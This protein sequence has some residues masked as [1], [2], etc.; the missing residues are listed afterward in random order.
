VPAGQTVQVPVTLQP[1]QEGNGQLSG[2]LT[3]SL[4][5]A[6]DPTRTT[7]APIRYQADMVR[8]PQAPVKIAILIAAFL[9]CLLIPLFLIWLARRLGARF[10]SGDRVALQAVVIEVKIGTNL[11]SAGGGTLEVPPL[12]SPV[13][14]P[15]PGRRTLSLSGV[16][17]SAHAGW[18]FTEPGYAVVDDGGDSVGACS[19]PPHS[20]SHGRPRLPLSVQGTWTVLIPRGPAISPLTELSG[21][22][23]LVV[24]TAADIE[25]RRRLIADA[26]RD[27]PAAV[28]AARVKAKAAVPAVDTDPPAGPGSAAPAEPQYAPFGQA[29]PPAWGEA[30]PNGWGQPGGP[31]QQTTGWGQP[32]TP[33]PSALGWGAAGSTPRPNPRPN[34]PTNPP[35]SD[36]W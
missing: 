16:P 13:P 4:A 11:S 34:P 12:W 32:G 15:G 35:R 14:D 31:N 8:L 36:G 24:D 21:R 19:N 30:Q 17:L 28:E 20:D 2:E 18:R 9:L 3:V 1:G 23:L 6:G 33:G 27:A 10:P 7:D 26:E 5:P 29:A 22:L 25:A